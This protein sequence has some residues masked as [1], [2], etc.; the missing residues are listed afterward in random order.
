MLLRL[1]QLTAHAFMLPDLIEDLFNLEDV[2]TMEEIHASELNAN[3]R[4]MLSTMRK[5]IQTRETPKD[6]TEDITSKPLDSNCQGEEDDD[7]DEYPPF[8]AKFRKFLRNLANSSKWID[9]NNRTVCHRCKD[10]PDDP[11][12]TD[13]EHLYCYECLEFLDNKAGENGELKSTCLQCGRYITSSHPCRGIQE[14]GFYDK[15]IT[16]ANGKAPKQK[17]KQKKKQKNP[18]EE[19]KW[20]N[21]DGKLLLSSKV[22]A[23]QTQIENWLEEDRTK[24]IIV[25]G[26][27]RPLLVHII[28]ANLID[29]LIHIPG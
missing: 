29:L 25:F 7:D 1:R 5:M 6:I 27:F 20:I 22:L 4:D 3:E 23:V 26:Q 11:W 9:Y 14:L 28:F 8:V 18:D 13:C 15:D 16:S 21:L 10:Q 19:I 24:K 17:Q 2:R 12:V